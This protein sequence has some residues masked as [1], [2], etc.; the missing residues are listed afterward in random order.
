MIFLTLTFNTF[1]AILFCVLTYAYHVL[2]GMLRS[3]PF[4][5]IL[6]YSYVDIL[7]STFY[8]ILFLSHSNLTRCKHIYLFVTRTC[9]KML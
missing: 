1:L 2:Y 6:F 8:F 9:I 5:F 4:F 3:I 7:M